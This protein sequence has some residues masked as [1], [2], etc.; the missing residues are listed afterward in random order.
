MIENRM[1]IYRILFISDHGDAIGGAERSMLELVKGLMADG[2]KIF[3]IL[4]GNGAFYQALEQLGVQC[5]VSVMP[6]IERNTSVRYV[7]SGI[8]AL[9]RFAFT[10][11]IWCLRNKIQIIHSNKTTSL[12]YSMALSLLSRKTLI[13]HARSY[14]RNFGRI[15]KLAYRFCDAVICISKNLAQPFYEVLGQKK[16]HIVYNGVS[17]PK[18]SK[19]SYSAGKCD[20]LTGRTGKQH[21][22][23]VVGRITA[24]KS[25]ETFIDAI[26]WISKDYQYGSVHGLIVGDC[27]TSN[28]VQMDDDTAYKRSLINRVQRHGI[29]NRITFTGF[30][31]N[32]DDIISE[33]EAL[34]LPSVAEPFGRI[35]IEAMALGIP[36]IAARAGGIPEIV[37]DE[38]SGLLFKPRDSR[39]LASLIVSI[40][41]DP[42]KKRNLAREGWERAQAVFSTEAYVRNVEKI[43]SELLQQD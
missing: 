32:P 14:N 8:F 30:I 23:G 20:A 11:L 22:V 19:I 40:I 37:I 13:W 5:R 38:K 2:H 4:P 36:V 7:L 29:E 26:K 10:N 42:I 17:V 3:C 18:L 21:Y 9:I 39:E 33:L 12:F 15:G 28:P 31:A 27:V 24:C 35:L 43:Y 34:V 16:I 25:I 41:D 1:D 6:V